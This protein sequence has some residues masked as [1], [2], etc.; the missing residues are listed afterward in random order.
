MCVS[1]CLSVCEDISGTARAIFTNFCACCLWPW[2]GFPAA[3]LRYVCT[4][5]FVDDIM[6]FLHNRQYGGI[7]F[8][9]MDRFRLN[10]IIYSKIGHNSIFFY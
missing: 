3:S 7:N 1:V 5:S 10:L 9:T 6:F 4:S 8:A 2:L